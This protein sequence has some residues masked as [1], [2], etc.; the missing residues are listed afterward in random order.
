[1]EH[2][3]GLSHGV[4][5]GVKSGKTLHLFI[6]SIACLEVSKLLSHESYHF[7][8]RSG[9]YLRNSQGEIKKYWRLPNSLS[10]CP[11]LHISPAPA[12]LL[13]VSCWARR[14]SPAPAARSTSHRCL[15]HNTQHRCTHQW[16]HETKGQLRIR[17]VL[18]NIIFFSVAHG[19]VQL[20]LIVSLLKW[21]RQ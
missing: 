1:M 17:I 10:P 12:G 14:E 11:A 15:L 18:L 16:C 13:Q 21:K 6:V 2:C 7:F 4:P 3:K 8:F 20:V 19:N 9:T 5:A